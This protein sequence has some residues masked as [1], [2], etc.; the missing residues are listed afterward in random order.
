MKAITILTL[1]FLTL[2][3]FSCGQTTEQ[4]SSK[5]EFKALASLIS[6]GE[7]SKIYTAKYKIIKDFTDT[8]FAD[9]INVGYYS[10]KNNTKQY[11]TVLLTLTKYE[12][13]T[14]IKNY[15][16]CPDYDAKIGIQKAKV[17]F[18]DFDYW[19]GCETGKGKCNPLNFTRTKDEKNWYLIMPCGGTETSI[20]FS[21]SD[22]TFSQ[23]QHLFFEKCLPYLELTDLKDGKY[24]A[25]MMACGLGGGVE[26]NLKTIN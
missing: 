9:T 15:F 7:G 4:K 18:I 12:G 2:T 3:L 14:T 16:I 20:T 17:N 24:F 10:Y 23:K 5:T 11:D 6:G 21:N 19:E 25:Y 1:L 22:K 13:Q 26:F 8:T